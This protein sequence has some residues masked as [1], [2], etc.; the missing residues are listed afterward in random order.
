MKK[1]LIIA[2]A[3]VNHNGSIENAKKM[4]ETAAQAGADIVKFQ[5]FK[6]ES[7]V[8]KSATKAEYQKQNMAGDSDDSQ[9]NMLKRLELSYENHLTL[10]DHCEKNN[11]RFH[12]TAF[13]LDSIELLNQ[14][15]M[16]IWKIPS[17]EITNLP[18]LKKIGSYGKDVILSTGMCTMDEIR[19]AVEIL[20]KNGTSKEKITVLHCNTEYP[21]PMQD[22]NLTAMLAIKDKVGTRVGYSDHTMGIEIS[23]AAAALGAETI[24]KHFTL[25]RNMD[26]P[27]HKASLEPE[28]LKRMVSSIRNIEKALGNGEKIPSLSELKNIT[29]VRKSIHL[30]KRVKAGQ[31]ISENDLIMVRPGDGISPME[32]YNVIGKMLI[33]DQEEGHKLN[34]S[35]L[36]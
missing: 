1:V 32:M 27:D 28:E 16:S 21:T 18:Y 36:S 30:S 26:G 4:I 31:I 7:L 3:G 20:I 13:D 11:I 33:A 6:T 19:S 23:I 10:I 12:S 5:T 35:D 8:S 24:E 22:V 14:L 9:F 15:G 25:D 29:V 2:E 34:W 17:G